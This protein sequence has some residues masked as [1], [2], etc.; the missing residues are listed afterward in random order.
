MHTHSYTHIH[1]HT[2]TYTCT[3]KYDI[4]MA[5]QSVEV[6]TWE[7]VSKA[8]DREEGEDVASAT[9]RAVKNL[10][11]HTCLVKCWMALLPEYNMERQVRRRDRVC[12]CCEMERELCSFGCVCQS[13]ITCSH[14]DSLTP[15]L[16]HTFTIS[17]CHYHTVLLTH[18]LIYSLCS[19]LS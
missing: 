12:G 3:L 8:Q 2:Y 16:P 15:S 4:L 19:S 18:P 14:C 9:K 11:L 13:S 1:T 6:A 17:L 5:A 10:S 7:L